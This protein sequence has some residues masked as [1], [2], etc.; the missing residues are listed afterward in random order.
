MWVA[1]R[2]MD[3]RRLAL[4]SLRAKIKPGQTRIQMR[5]FRAIFFA[6]KRSVTKKEKCPLSS[7]KLIIFRLAQ[8]IKNLLDA[9]R[10]SAELRITGMMHKPNFF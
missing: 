2:Y 7:K 6:T 10:D 8:T 3:R 9:M 1:T 4:E 5:N